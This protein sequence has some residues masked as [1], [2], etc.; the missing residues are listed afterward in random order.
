[1]TIKLGSTDI[2]QIYLGS[3]AINRVYQGTT[4]IYST[5]PAPTPILDTYPAQAAYSLR[6]LRTGQTNAIR[7]RRASDDTEQ[8]IGFDAN[9]DMDTTAL[10]TFCAGTDGF[11]VTWYDQSGNGSD[12]TQSSQGNQP[13]I[14]SS[15][16]TTLDTDTGEPTLRFDGAGQSFSVADSGSLDI[17]RDVGHGWAF[18]V[19]Q[20]NLD[21]GG[22]A[23]VRQ[24]SGSGVAP[25]RFLLSHNTAED[26]RF[27]LAGRRLDSD[28]FQFIGSDTDHTTNTR[29]VTGAM[30]WAENDALLY[31]DG[32]LVASDADFQSSAGKTEDTASLSFTI[33][34]NGV[35]TE[36]WDGNM[37]ELIIFNTDQSSSRTAIEGDI[38]GHYAIY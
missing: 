25:N 17:F 21:T 22:R 38:N 20:L 26:N 35:G 31:Q 32:Q 9:G 8:D 13:K 34:Q 19:V 3:T 12:A 14:V 10:E 4:E 33:G 30:Q 27:R 23:I 11:V 5:G 1:M 15:G 7:V 29:L 36:F 24:S 6:K 28:S 16:S 18:S 2:N 37:Q